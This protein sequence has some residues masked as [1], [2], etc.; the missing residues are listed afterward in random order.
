[1]IACSASGVLAAGRTGSSDIAAPLPSD[2]I[3]TPPCRRAAGSIH[4]RFLG[5]CRMNGYVRGLEAVTARRQRARREAA[6][7]VHR[8]LDVTSFARAVSSS[9]AHAVS[10]EGT[11]LLTLDPA[12]LLPTGEVIDN[13]LPAAVM[14]RMTESNCGS[15]TSTSSPR[16]PRSPSGSHRQRGDRRRPPARW[17]AACAGPPCS[18]ARPPAT[19]AGPACWCSRPT[20]LSSWP[21]RG[22]PLAGGAVRRQ[23]TGSLPPGRYPRRRQP[24]TGRRRR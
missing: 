23:R 19:T 13:G 1:M 20:R 5:D 24:G 6:R 22:R 18:R 3:V 10:C 4:P 21:I 15:A 7:L 16:W 8:G 17:P 12:T 11:C 2:R 14:P 9:V